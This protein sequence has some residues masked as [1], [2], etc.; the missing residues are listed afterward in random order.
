MNDSLARPVPDAAA[1]YSIPPPP[2]GASDLSSPPQGVG[3]STAYSEK[4][5]N[6]VTQSERID[7]V[8][9]RVNASREWAEKVKTDLSGLKSGFQ[10]LR[11]G[12]DVLAEEITGLSGALGRLEQAFEQQAAATPVSTIDPVFGYQPTPEQLAALFAALAEW[13]TGAQELTKGGT[14]SFKTNSGADASYDY[15]TPGDVSNLARTAGAQGLSHWHREIVL[16][17]YSVIRTY[18]VHKAGGFIYCDVPLLQKENKLLSPIQSWAAANTA[19]QRLG[20]LSVLGILPGDAD[21][22]GNLTTGQGRSIETRGRGPVSGPGP[23]VSKPPPLPAEN[24][25]RVGAT[26]T[27]TPA[28]AAGPVSAA[29]PAASD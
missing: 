9:R 10:L 15:A 13:Q 4:P 12:Q 19:A 17:G 22:A 27:S 5:T 29:R 7:E 18:L 14:A 28:P 6:P 21:D 8:E 2:G 3:T 1:G 16:P 23:G 24:I 20:I 11:N 25:R 26:T